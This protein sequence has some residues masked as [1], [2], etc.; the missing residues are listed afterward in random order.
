MQEVATYYFNKEEPNKS[1]LLSLRTIILE[2]HSGITET[3]KWGTP[4]FSFKNKML[5]FLAVT[6]KTGIPYILFV[7]GK[8]LNDPELETGNRKRMK[9][10]AID[11]LKDIPKQ[12]I[13]QILNTA[14]NVYQYKK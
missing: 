4:C 14:L 9:S 7:E 12:R 10:L 13:Q 3:L 6:K 5:C 2:Q 11:P 1:C 8:Y